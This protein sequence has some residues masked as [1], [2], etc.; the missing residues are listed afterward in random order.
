MPDSILKKSTG[1]SV[2]QQSST[3]SILKQGITLPS[4]QR[5]GIDIDKFDLL[6]TI[7]PEFGIDEVIRQRAQNQSGFS[8]LGN[9]IGRVAVNTIPTVIGNTASILDFEDY[10]NQDQ[11]VGNAITNAMEEFKS[12]VN[13]DYFPI[14][15]ENP[16]EH[17]DL[18]DSGWWFENGASLVESIG[19]FAITGALVGGALG[20]A[21]N[22]TKTGV[23]GQRAAT[24]LNATV[25]NQAESISIASQVYN[26]TLNEELGKFEF[27][28]V[29]D[30]DRAK[31]IASEAA[32]HTVNINRAN[33]LLNLT[34]AN[35]FIRT[36]QSTRTLLNEISKKNTLRKG[37]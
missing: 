14:Y 16:G 6:P 30:V 27:P 2:T 22:I 25:L 35:L 11:E 4:G 26:Q 20:L 18:G 23:W 29:E 36:P 17:L 32:A 8:Q 33:V 3:D 37:S 1:S 15:R 12:T 13:Q 5:S 10:F 28:T 24:L 34:S 9:A 31:T 19:G 7:R 21:A